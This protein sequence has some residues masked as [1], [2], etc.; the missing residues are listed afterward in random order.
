MRSK[1]PWLPLVLMLL[2][3]HQA[4]AKPVT[5]FELQH[6]EVT[7][8]TI[9]EIKRSMAKKSPIRTGNKGFGGVT[10]WSLDTTYTTVETP[11]GGCEVRD[12]KVFL[13]VKIVLPKLRPGPRLSRQARAE[14]ERFLGALRAHEMLHA[15]NGLYTAETIEKR[16]TNLRTKVSCHR[17]KE[18]LNQ[19]SQA[20]I[21][22]ITQR[23]RDMDRDT[24]HGETQGAYLDERVDRQQQAVRR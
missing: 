11:D 24:R 13:K 6:Y 3:S 10:V 16:M 15:K 18:V 21:S 9:A 7:G 22:N 17:T 8:S 19:G 5:D 12:P 2:A 14:W 4:K 20:L 23:D 1:R